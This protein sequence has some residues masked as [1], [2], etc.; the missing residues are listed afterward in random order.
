MTSTD[1]LSKTN[2]K[3]NLGCGNKKMEGF[4]NIDSSA[5][6]EPDII[7][8][9]TNTPY[10]FKSN[11]VNEIVMKSVIEHLPADPE[12]F[13]KILQEIYRIC[14][15]NAVIHIECPHPTHRW[16]IADF[17]HQKAIHPEGIRLLSKKACEKD[18]NKDSTASPLAIIY[19]IDFE[20]R[21]Y[22]CEVDP[23]CR[24]H[25]ENLFG[26]FDF[27][28]LDSYAYLFKDVASKQ[29]FQLIAKKQ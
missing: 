13:L 16:Q 1:I 9:L 15:H 7:L 18:I 12:K 25:I 6:C 27:S 28:K 23:K 20:M 5:H 29:K 17:T 19:D 11:S 10:P 22:A 24:E 8:N 26:E 21:N 4:I 2:L 14:Q 3:L